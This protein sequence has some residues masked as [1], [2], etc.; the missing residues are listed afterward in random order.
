MSDTVRRDKLGRI[1]PEF[2][3]TKSGKKAAETAKERYGEDFHK[4]LAARGGSQKTRGYFGYLKE[5]DPEGLK[6]LVK[7]AGNTPK[8]PRKVVDPKPDEEGME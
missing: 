1:I 8:K 5:E 4:R 7:R 2:D 3:R 6:E